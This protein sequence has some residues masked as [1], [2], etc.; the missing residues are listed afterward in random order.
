V[1][2]P[3]DYCQPRVLSIFAPREDASSI[4]SEHTSEK[5]RVSINQCQESKNKSVDS[6]YHPM[7]VTQLTQNKVITSINVHHIINRVA[8]VWHLSMYSRPSGPFRRYSFHTPPGSV[9]K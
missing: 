1:T 4:L 7:M 9:A 3:K 2:N 5:C 8:A 6:H